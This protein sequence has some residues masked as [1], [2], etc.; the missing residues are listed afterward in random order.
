M[1]KAIREAK[2]EG[3]VGIEAVPTS[4]VEVID[5]TVTHVV[6]SIILAPTIII[7]TTKKVAIAYLP[8]PAILAHTHNACYN[9]LM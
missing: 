7:T 1:N 3:R 5:C 9:D 4:I 8:G 2:R 6:V